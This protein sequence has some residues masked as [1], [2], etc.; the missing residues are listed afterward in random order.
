[1]KNW[2][3]MTNFAMLPSSNTKITKTKTKAKTNKIN[4][5]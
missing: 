4:F 1:M 5:I 3:K 2:Q